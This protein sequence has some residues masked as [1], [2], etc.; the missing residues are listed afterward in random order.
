MRVLRQQK[1]QALVELGLILPLLFLLVFGAIE[2]SSLIDLHLTLTHL[3][4]EG[5]NLTSRDRTLTAAEIQS[6]LNSVIDAAKPTLCRD[7]V[8]CT[9]NLS[10][11]YVIYSQIVYDSVPG[12]CGSPLSN[13]DPDYYRIVRLGT[14][15]KGS[16]AHASKVGNHGA[17]AS[18]SADLATTIKG[19][20][21]NQTF[22]V[23]EA[24]YDYGPNK[25]TPIEN[26]LGFALPAFFYDRSVFTQV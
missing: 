21:G 2:F 13:G 1:G 4:R 6:Y 14:W 7:G 8:G 26:F 19:M 12:P 24:F 5:T 9:Q 25:M 18:A 22:H 17:C 15:T 3:T 20:S 10:Q 11:W 16:F 23:V